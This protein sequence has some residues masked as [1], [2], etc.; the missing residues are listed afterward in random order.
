MKTLASAMHSSEAELDLSKT[1]RRVRGAYDLEFLKTC[2]VLY[3]GAGGAVSFAEDNSRAGIGEHILV[4]PDVVSETNIATQQVYRKDLGRPKVDCVA[5]RLV[6]INPNAKTMALQLRFEE[7]SDAELKNLAVAPLWGLQPRRTL[8]CALTDQFEPQARVNRAALHFGLPS[9]SAQ[10]YREGRGAEITF[11]Y[12]GVTPACHRCVLRSR[13]EAY[14]KRGFRND[15]TSDGTP[16]YTTTRLN[17]LKGMI[18]MAILHHGTSHPRWGGLL[19][20][21]GNRNLVQIRMDPDVATT[22]GLTVFE[23]VFGGCDSQRIL[24]DEAVWLPQ[25][26]DCPENGYP[27]CPDCGGT[28]DLRKAIG[29]FADTRE[30][31][32]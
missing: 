8:I 21:I 22:L 14:L 11:T 30:M 24:F 20:R 4:D 2:R 31:L 5:E 19:A 27:T 15:V 7:I 13:Y 9:L 6:D 16:I 29:T 12:P 10:V 32:R 23:R 17:A 18:T 28:G 3:I 1:F 26:P 25:K